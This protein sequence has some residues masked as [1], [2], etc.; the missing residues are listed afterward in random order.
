MPTVLR[1]AQPRPSDHIIS[2]PAKAET[3]FS[4]FDRTSSVEGGAAP[5]QKRRVHLPDLVQS[6]VHLRDEELIDLIRAAIGEARRRGIGSASRAGDSGQGTAP[7]EE[8]PAPAARIV[9]A[10]AV[11]G[12]V[13]PA[14][15]NMIRAAVRAGFSP[16]RVAREFGLSQSTVRK[17]SA[18]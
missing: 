16:A 13:P 8:P 2:M 15:A 6:V 10:S 3:Q 18:T 9:R 5:R 12:G 4:L 7:A 1:L 11:S 17:L 14:K